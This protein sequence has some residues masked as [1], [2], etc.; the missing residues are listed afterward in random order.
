[1]IS[2]RKTNTYT[3][4]LALAFILG[5][6]AAPI[7]TVYSASSYKIKGN[8]INESG[9]ALS[10][11]KLTVYTSLDIVSG[12]NL[13]SD[14]ITSATTDEDGYFK[15]DLERDSYTFVFEKTGYVS[16]SLTVNLNSAT[17]YTYTIDDI[18]MEKSLSISTTASTLLVHDG[19]T[20]S[21]PIMVANGGEVTVASIAV[22]NNAG[23]T[24]SVYNSNNQ[25]VQ[26]LS[27]PSGSSTALTLKVTAPEN[28]VD[29]DLTMKLVGAVET[30]Y[31]VHL[32][33][34]AE[35]D[36]ALSCTYTGRSVMPSESIDYT[37]TVANPYYYTKAFSLDLV[38]PDNW[39]FYIKNGAG[40][41]INSVTLGAGETAT[42]HLIGTV[43]SSTDKGDYSLSLKTAYD[44]KTETLP[45]TITVK[46][47][48]PELQITSKYPS[49]TVS[50]G[51][52]TTYPVT[53]TNPGAK[54]LVSLKAKGIPNGWTVTFKTSTGVQI[55]SILLDSDSSES[56][57]IEVTPSLDA[58]NNSYEITVTASS[59]YTSGE[60]KLE[61]KIG[62]SYGLTMTVSSLYFETYAGKTTTNV[63][64]L[65]NTGFSTLNNLELS[66]TAPS[67]DWN[68]TVSPT[69]V[70]TLDPDGKASFT[71][72]ITPPSDAS[73]QDYLIYV[74]ATS[75]EVE[76]AQQSIRVTINTES[77]YGI[78]GLVLLLAGIGVFVLLYKKLKRK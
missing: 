69:R 67:S 18:V 34:V 72:T 9:A 45:L 26:S 7:A 61:A 32:E 39:T 28:A 31:V 17:E 19:E 78:Y 62:G 64:T 56:L 50:L 44:G 77:S 40:E 30:T 55:N 51:E 10:D 47:E 1:M 65:T 27:F 36:D 66:I 5:M 33:V 41:Q 22:E 15:V 71:L 21:I 6:L 37:V 52:T 73:P 8:V 46:L 63:V 13:I 42:I 48:S 59:D 75:N 3:R 57:N 74:T 14:Y 54:Q 25:L 70:T 23:Y 60:I 35:T 16:I 4:I 29:T 76:T 43:P 24:S 53:L 11:V 49:Q 12:S 38:T 68:V 2:Q 20:F 58:G